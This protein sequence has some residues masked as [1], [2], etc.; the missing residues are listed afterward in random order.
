[1]PTFTSRL[2]LQMD[3]DTENYDVDVVNGNSLKIDAN[4]GVVM[5]TSATRPSTPYDGQQIYET[6]TG[7]QGIWR[8]AI[9]TWTSPRATMFSSS[10][11]PTVGLYEG[12]TFYRTDRD[13]LETWD[14]GSWRVQNVAICS[15]PADLSAVDFPKS[16]QLAVTVDRDVLW[17]YDGVTSSWVPMGPRLV[18]RHRRTTTSAGSTSNS[19]VAVARLDGVPGIPG[20]ALTVR[21]GSLH[22]TSTNTADTMR[23]EI[24]YAVGGAAATTASTV[25]PGAL[26]F[27]NWGNTGQLEATIVPGS[28]TTYSF[29]LCFARELGSGTATLFADGN[30]LI[31]I[32]AYDESEDP[33][34]TGVNL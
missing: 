30:R 10:I 2:G 33:G 9:S 21:T 14:G 32:K 3:A 15:N 27:E 5:C 20:R 23:C 28:N 31:E 17:Q 1:M 6:D 26:I 12:F 34:S 25:L 8:S 4:I 19:A 22:P 29:L 24:R 18:K 13:W 16:G 11:R 7:F